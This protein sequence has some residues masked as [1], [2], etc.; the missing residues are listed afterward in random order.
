MD[1]M[2]SKFEKVYEERV[3]SLLADRYCCRFK[4]RLP[5]IWVSRFM[6]MSNGNEIVLKGYPADRKIMQWTNHV[7][8]H[9]EFID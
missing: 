8:R 3:K 1:M 9:S 7:L 2:G 5:Y 6:H 4:S